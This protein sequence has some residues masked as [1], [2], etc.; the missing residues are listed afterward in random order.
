MTKGQRAMIAAKIFSLNEKQEDQA[1]KLQ[2]SM[3]YVGQAAIVLEY[4]P[5]LADSVIA[6]AAKVQS[7]NTKYSTT[8]ACRGAPAF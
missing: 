3:G 7:L 5:E 8:R 2:V 4:A 6:G 1:K